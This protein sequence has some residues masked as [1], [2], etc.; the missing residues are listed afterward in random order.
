MISLYA[1]LIELGVYHPNFRSALSDIGVEDAE[2][3]RLQQAIAK[4]VMD[5]VLNSGKVASI[6]DDIPRQ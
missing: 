1:L 3:K 4:E 5:V 6:V 2:I